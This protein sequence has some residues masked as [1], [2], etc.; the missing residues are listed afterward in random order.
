[1]V[2]RPES[3]PFS[4]MI[5]LLDTSRRFENSVYR[6]GIYLHCAWVFSVFSA[7]QILSP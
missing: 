6:M 1:M 3:I 5:A 7:R 4:N 2:S